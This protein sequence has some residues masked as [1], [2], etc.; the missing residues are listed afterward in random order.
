MPV[1]SHRH[2]FL[3][4]YLPRLGYKE[5]AHLMNPMV[6][7]LSQAKMSS[8]DPDSKIDLLDSADSIQKKIRKVRVWVCPVVYICWV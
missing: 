8:S 4:R 6:P 5:R 1:Y 7:G 3:D 2:F